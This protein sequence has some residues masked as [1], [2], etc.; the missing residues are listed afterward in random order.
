MSVSSQVDE[1]CWPKE[2]RLN[3]K[4]YK[5]SLH[6]RFWFDDEQLC[7]PDATNI[8]LKSESMQAGVSVF[9]KE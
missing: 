5:N 8:F 6:I 9:C 2:R 4:V 3:D 7:Y 1:A